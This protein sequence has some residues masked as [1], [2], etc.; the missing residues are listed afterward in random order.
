MKKA[1]CLLLSAL[2][3]LSLAS[4]FRSSNSGS[5]SDTPD[6]PSGSANTEPADPFT[7]AIDGLPDEAAADVVL[8]EL[9][10]YWNSLPEGGPYRFFC[11]EVRDGE[12][13][14]AEGIWA[15]DVYS[16]GYVTA[17]EKLSASKV[18]IHALSPAI[19]PGEMY[20][21]G[22][23]EYAFYADVDL[24]ELESQILTVSYNE[25]EE[26]VSYTYAGSNSDEAYPY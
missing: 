5:G 20:P 13:F 21:E 26:T 11:I 18:R 25:A 24:S 23:P 17:V 3:A 14:A 22:I 10:G 12:W 15:S 8:T 2:L 4:C 19:E 16:A 1:L 6:D 9:T 7:A